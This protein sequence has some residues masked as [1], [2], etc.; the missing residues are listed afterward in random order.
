MKITVDKNKE[1]GMEF[2]TSFTSEVIVESAGHGVILKSED[3]QRIQVST[4]ENGF[5]VRVVDIED[6]PRGDKYYEIKGGLVTLI[7]KQSV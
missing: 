5:E 7:T 3:G 2:Y 4:T 1:H 6:D